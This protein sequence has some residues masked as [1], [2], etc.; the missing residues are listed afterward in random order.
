MRIF[1]EI[2]IIR[3][4]VTLD[5]AFQKQPFMESVMKKN[6][7]SRRHFLEL[8]ALTPLAAMI[9]R[10]LLFAAEAQTAPRFQAAKPVWAAGR[11]NE[12]SRK[13]VFD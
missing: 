12:M 8:T 13:G 1:A 10:D 3:W 9:S 4:E 7:L 6:E 5:Y 2:G 11:E